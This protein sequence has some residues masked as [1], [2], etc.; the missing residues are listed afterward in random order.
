[1]F[2]QALHGVA[3]LEEKIMSRQKLEELCLR[4]TKCR[5]CFEQLPLD[6]PTI[7]IAQPRWVGPDYWNSSKRIAVVMINPGSGDTRDDPADVSARELL[8]A[9][10]EGRGTL[11]AFF[12]HQAKDMRGWGQHCFLPFYTKN[13]GLRFEEVAFA[14]IAWCATQGNKYPRQ[15]LSNCFQ[16]HTRMLLQILDPYVILLSGS[17]AHAFSTEVGFAVPNARII[18][19]LHFAHR[20]G[21]GVSHQ[22]GTRVRELLFGKPSLHLDLVENN[23]RFKADMRIITVLVS[24][25][26]KK[27][28][29]KSYDRFNLYKTGMTVAE[30]V[31]AGGFLGDIRWD[32]RHG[33]ISVANIFSG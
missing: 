19:M 11:D 16:R 10:S 23:T 6:A 2:E 32:V 15:M 24:E 3:G 29:S 30:Y 14:N 31:A 20:G 33:F 25:N 1:L 26:P 22:E 7:D 17:P 12:D 27:V 8:A 4:A 9:F 5:V 18:R 13:L 21:Y 28:G